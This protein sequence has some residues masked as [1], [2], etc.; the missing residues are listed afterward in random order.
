MPCATVICWS[1]LCVWRTRS[2]F[3][4]TL[5]IKD[6]CG[7][8]RLD[9]ILVG[10][11]GPE[12]VVVGDEPANEFVQAALEDLVDTAVLEP[13]ADRTGLALRR[14]VAAVSIGDVVEITDEVLIAARERTRHLVVEHQ[15]VGDQ[16]G[17]QALAVDPMISGQRRYQAQDR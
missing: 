7:A 14:A 15:Q 1:R 4:T 8:R 3:G 6:E 12:P 13:R 16:P 5:V 9:Q 11:C 10:N 2:T 17:L